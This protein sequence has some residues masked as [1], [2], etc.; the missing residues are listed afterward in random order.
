M[1]SFNNPIH[2]LSNKDNI[3]RKDFKARRYDQNTEKIIVLLDPML[4]VLN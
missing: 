3:I 2:K 4:I 1:D